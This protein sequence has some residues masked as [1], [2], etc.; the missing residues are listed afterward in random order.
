MSSFQ[1][2]EF[3][4]DLD[5]L[6]KFWLI[7]DKTIHWRQGKTQPNWAHD[8]ILCKPPAIRG[9]SW[10][11][12]ENARPK[13]QQLHSWSVRTDKIWP[14][15]EE[16]VLCPFPQHGTKGFIL[17][18]LWPDCTIPLFHL[19]A[20]DLSSSSALMYSKRDMPSG[21]LLILLLNFSR[22]VMAHET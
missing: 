14:G 7:L 12:I 17:G 15:V 16:C 6:N 11:N 2:L 20:V 4:A 3:G 1:L 8:Q 21:P 10:N 18:S 19:M 9:L 13:L 22:K 5:K